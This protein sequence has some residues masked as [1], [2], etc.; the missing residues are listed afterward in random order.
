MFYCALKKGLAGVVV[1]GKQHGKNNPSRLLSSCNND[2]YIFCKKEV[3]VG[4]E[5]S[6]NRRMLTFLFILQFRGS[7]AVTS[8]SIIIYSSKICMQEILLL[9]K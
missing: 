1:F 8:Y 3:F 6:M 2:I 4:T 5:S 9:F 7:F